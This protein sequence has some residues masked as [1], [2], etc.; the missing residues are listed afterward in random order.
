MFTTK[1]AQ[2][3]LVATNTAHIVLEKLRIRRDQPMKLRVAVIFGGRSGEHEVSLAS[4]T[5][6]MENLDRS[7][8]E[9]IPIGI[10]KDGRWLLEG[11]PLKALQAG[12]VKAGQEPALVSLAPQP[13]QPVSRESSPQARRETRL[14]I[15]VAFPV[16]HGPYGEDGTVQGLLEMAGVPYVGAGVLASAAGMD[17]AIMKALFQQRG[18]PI[19]KHLAMARREWETDP[20][21]VMDRIED[22]LGY[23]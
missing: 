10:T 7:K 4:A 22:A 17:K 8:Y 23:P 2:K 14:A 11:E 12:Y 9:V 13:S 18:L 3:V 20:E 6:I 21:G 5:S 19:V 16:M 1:M 15:D